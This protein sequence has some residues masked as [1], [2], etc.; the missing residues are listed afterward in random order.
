MTAVASYPRASG[1]RPASGGSVWARRSRL[2]LSGFAPVLILTGLA[3]LLLPP[4][5]SLMSSAPPYDVFHIAFGVVGVGIVLSRSAVGA[6]LFNVAFGAIDLYQA[7]AGWGGLFP[8]RAF[9]LRPADHAVHLV[10][11]LVL[12]GIGGAALR[13]T[14]RA[15]GRS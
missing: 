9:A 15:P 14:A 1:G 7:A 8:A 2:W 6:A 10:L 11:G 3:G 5:L 12:V 4:G 13:S